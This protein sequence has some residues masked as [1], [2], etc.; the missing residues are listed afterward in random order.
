M[1]FYSKLPNTK[2]LD[3]W[4]ELEE[5]GSRIIET[6]PFG[7][8][9]EDM[10]GFLSITGKDNELPIMTFCVSNPTKDKCLVT[11]IVFSSV[12]HYNKVI[13]SINIDLVRYFNTNNEKWD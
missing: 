9:L 4:K 6:I 13:D 10:E 12:E 11:N 2:P 5:S 8:S 3:I 7:S 1:S